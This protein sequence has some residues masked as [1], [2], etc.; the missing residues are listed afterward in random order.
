MKE[1]KTPTH[2]QQVIQQ[3]RDAFQKGAPLTANP[4]IDGT[5][6]AQ[7]WELGW[8]ELNRKSRPK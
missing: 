3:G 2:E 5:G 4:Y 7:Y 8:L 1:K 6:D